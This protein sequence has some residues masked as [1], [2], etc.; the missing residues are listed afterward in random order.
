M[1][2]DARLI[3]NKAE[4]KIDFL[5]ELLEREYIDHGNQHWIVFCQD[6]DQ[7]S[8]ARH[9]IRGQGIAPYEY[10]SDAEGAF[11]GGEQQEWDR[12]ETISMFEKTG[13]VILVIN[14]VDEGISI[15]RLT[16]GVVLAS[17]KNPRQFIQR[18]GRLLR[19][20]DSP[21][22]TKTFAKIWDPLVL[23]GKDAESNRYIFDEIERARQFD[24]FSSNFQAVQTL[25]KIIIRYNLAGSSDLTAEED[26]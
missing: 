12:E 1:L 3:I 23:P 16:H 5:D 10:W 15:D 24:E 7:L 25:N 17:S 6:R 13:G 8:K 26:D 14:M 11:V 20:F 22:F 4:A 21:E 9:K 18:R 19:N 2:K